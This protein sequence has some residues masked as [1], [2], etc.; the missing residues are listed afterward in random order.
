MSTRP[1]NA[2]DRGA[3][4]YLWRFSPL[5][6]TL[7]ALVIVSF[8]GLVMT[9]LPLKFAYAPWA[10]ALVGLVGG[11]ETAG[12]IHRICAVITFGYFLT[13]VG[14]LIYRLITSPN[15]KAI[16]WGP[17]SMTPQ[18]K[19]LQDIV[20]MFK[21]FLGKGPRP[22]FERYSYMEKFDYWAVFWG[23]AI[24]GTSG[25]MLWFPAFF[26]KLLPGWAFNI[27]TIIHSDEAL[28]ATAFIFTIHFFNVH[29]RPEKFPIDTVIFTGR[30]TTGYMKE[31]H[32]LEYD[33]AVA[34]GTLQAR[35]APP[36]SRAAYL[37]SVV[38]G[39]ISATIGII[40]VILVIWALLH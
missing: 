17:T 7:H 9:G 8:L 19:D 29:F 14:N 1:M 31:E 5:N 27:A 12:I 23:V 24:I 3:G 38:L 28:L 10:H 30:A 16:V 37:W 4:P 18:L 21:W 36:A 2:A 11:V 35:V 34:D 25:L 15:R 40:L 32:E 13:H 33:R 20:A 26:A 22:R 6:R 39:F